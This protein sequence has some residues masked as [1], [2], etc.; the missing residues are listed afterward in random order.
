MEWRTIPSN[1]KYEVSE[2]GQVRH[3]RLARQNAQHGCLRGYV[4]R[5]GYQTVCFVVNG[6]HTTRPVAHYVAEAFLGARPLGMTVN[7][8]DGN[9]RNDHWSNLEYC[10]R[11]DNVRHAFEHGLM[12]STRV[13][14]PIAVVR[15]IRAAY[16]DDQTQSYN[17]L[18]RRFQV[19]AEAV[20]RVVQQK[21]FRDEP[22]EV[23]W[24]RRSDHMRRLYQEGRITPA[25]GWNN[26]QSKLTQ[27]QYSLAIQLVRQGWSRQRVAK[28]F[29]VSHTTINKIVKEY[30]YQDS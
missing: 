18:A 5:R 9:K 2:D 7:H 22:P 14:T 28:R 17:A 1:V 25:Y 16:Q 8:K 6:K 13:S 15:Q 21:T 3:A 29:G 30:E 4:N 10:T 12:S 24:Q 23:T 11:L 19:S 20:S 26:P 27:E